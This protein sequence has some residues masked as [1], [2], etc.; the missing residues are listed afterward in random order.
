[1]KSL[2][3][4][5]A[6]LILC[7]VAACASSA[8]ICVYPQVV[9]C[10]CIG[11][12]IPAFQ[13]T[14]L[15]VWPTGSFPYVN[16]G[17][18]PPAP[19]MAAI[20]NWNVNLSSGNPRRICFEPVFTTH[21]GVYTLTMNYAP[22]PPPG[23]GLITRGRT[24]YQTFAN[25]HLLSAS[26][27][28]NSSVTYPPAITEVVAHEFGHM[29]GLADCPSPVCVAHSSVMVSGVKLPP[30]PD[31]QNDV[32]GLPGPACGDLVAMVSYS[33]T[34]SCPCDGNPCGGG[35][36]G[37]GDAVGDGITAPPTPPQPPSIS[38]AVHPMCNI[39]R[40]PASGGILLPTGKR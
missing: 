16:I 39:P 30:G 36:G 13:G 26:T 11:F 40:V 3:R 12:G 27:T 37:G 22:I 33:P 29:M 5:G 15:S 23:P 6:L 17:N 35:G 18:V 31:P 14:Y 20:A 25:G 28:I 1:M 32:V 19:V 38:Q 9:N 21:A 4:V 10:G 8:Q 7:G 34:W 24:T 2:A